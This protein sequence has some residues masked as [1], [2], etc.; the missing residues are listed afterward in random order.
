MVHLDPVDRRAP[1]R[2]PVLIE[3]VSVGSEDGGE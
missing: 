2:P 3:E 1:E